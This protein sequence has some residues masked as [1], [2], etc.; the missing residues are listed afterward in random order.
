MGNQILE[1]LRERLEAALLA[2]K[3]DLSTVRTG[4][5]KTSLVEDV[6]VE[7]YGSSMT[8]KELASITVP[9]PSLIIVSPWDKSLVAAIA[10][11]VQKAD[12]NLQAV[13]DGGSIK[14]AIPPLTEERRH[15]LVK[16]VHAKLE[17]GRVMLRT[18][19]TEIKEEIEAQKGESGISEDDVKAWLSEMQKQVDES[20]THV[21]TLGK[22][23][24]QELM[25]L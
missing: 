18:I 11:G 3:K 4:R 7:A 22:E 10:T 23:K 19:R 14:I 20:M 6:R 25:T 15:E 8:I 5:A 1:T 17:S 12:L 21:D 9:D 13:V 16:L 24:E 2:I